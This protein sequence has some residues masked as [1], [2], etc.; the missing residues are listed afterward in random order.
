MANFNNLSVNIVV[1]LV[2]FGNGFS[3]LVAQLTNTSSFLYNVVVKLT[4]LLLSC[5]LIASNLMRSR[6]GV[7]QFLA[8]SLFISA[9]GIA[10]GR[11][12]SLGQTDPHIIY[13]LAYGI[14]AILFPLVAF[15]IC[16]VGTESFGAVV[17]V[18]LFVFCLSTLIIGNTYELNTNGTFEDTGKLNLAGFNSIL[19]SMFGSVLFGISFLAL[20]SK[21]GRQSLN[22]I[23]IFVGAA[24]LF[25]GVSRGP[26]L[27]FLLS[28]FLIFD[29]KHLRFTI[30]LLLA[31]FM[32]NSDKVALLVGLFLDSK[33]FSTQER[34][35][36]YKKFFDA[37]SESLFLP[38]LDPVLLLENAHNIFLAM[39]SSISVFGLV[40]FLYLNVKALLVARK[41]IN[42]DAPDAW[43]GI[44]FVNVLVVSIFSGA[45]LDYYYWIFLVLLLGCNRRILSKRLVP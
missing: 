20:T 1:L 15:A 5:Y 44:F 31:L 4:I 38:I 40:V 3:A 39:Y 7:D 6:I 19:T 28:V 21:R 9:F 37:L 10:I 23:S 13:Y 42:T 34:L 45:I 16:K 17:Q 29:L 12:A 33:N 43:V 32:A 8:A 26:F 22:I 24:V 14:L 41:L 35:L 2:V 30:P 25:G 27:G 18:I 11:F 36:I